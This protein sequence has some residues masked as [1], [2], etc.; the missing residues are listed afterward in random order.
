MKKLNLPVIK[1]KTGIA[2]WLSMDDYVRFVNLNLKYAPNRNANKK[3]RKFSGVN[4]PF[5]IK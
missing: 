2:K 3:W 5:S 1:G 4:A